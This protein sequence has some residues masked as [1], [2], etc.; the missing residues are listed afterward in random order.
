VPTKSPHVSLPADVE[1]ILRLHLDFCPSQVVRPSIEAILER[2]GKLY[3]IPG[4]RKPNGDTKLATK[5][6]YLDALSDF[7]AHQG[8][9]LRSVGAV[10]SQRDQMQQQVDRATQ[11]RLDKL[12]EKVTP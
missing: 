5:A 11:T 10:Q 4:D 6:D 7:C 2:Q 8:I 12:G 1:N 3:T 9:D